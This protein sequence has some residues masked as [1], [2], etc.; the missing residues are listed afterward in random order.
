MSTMLSTLSS[1]RLPLWLSGKSSTAL[2]MRGWVI[3]VLTG[4][5]MFAVYIFA[6]FT[7]PTVTGAMSETTTAHMIK[8]FVNGDD[9][10]NAVMLFHIL[11]V[12]LL[13]LSGVLQ[14]VPSLRQRYPAFHR[15][16]GRFFL[17]IGLSGA[18]TGLWLTWGR[19]T[20]LSDIGGLGVT[21][22]GILIPV[23]VA[24]AWHYAKARQFVQHQRFA[25]HAFI[26]IN[27]VW[28]FRLLLMGWFMVNQGPNGNN[29]TLDGPMDLFLSFASYLLP[30]AI[31][32]V[33][34]WAQRRRSPISGL[35][36]N[37]ALLFAV[38]TT[39]TG[40]AAATL[41]MWWPRISAG[42]F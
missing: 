27:G 29:A 2:L 6:Q 7:W 38:A 26:L 34:F 9:V 24:L 39:A 22:N 41:M 30:M 3:A 8:G 31:A 18:L 40:V 25:I 37:S 14:L 5:W 17:L 35:L 10:G 33:Y 16:N 32:E 13:S 20:R 36:V 15:L 23:A 42:L 4:Q 21:L 19:D 12:M 11:P 1:I 28:S